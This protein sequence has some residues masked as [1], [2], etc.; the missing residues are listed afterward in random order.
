M[1]AISAALREVRGE[2]DSLVV[3]CTHVLEHVASLDRFFSGLEDVLYDGDVLYI[4]VPDVLRYDHV[5][6]V[7][8]AHKWHFSVNTLNRLFA[9]KGYRQ[10]SID[11][12]EPVELPKSIRAIFIK[13]SSASFSTD[14]E[15]DNPGRLREIF[16]EVAAT[17][18]VWNSMYRK[19]RRLLN[20]IITWRAHDLFG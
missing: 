12:Y 7:H 16:A 20:S 19:F 8:I 10:I 18:R 9:T 6:D 4:D 3:V 1:E 11:T 5:K 15:L 17:E 2:F 14:F 13:S